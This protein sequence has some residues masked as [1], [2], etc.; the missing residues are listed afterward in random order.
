MPQILLSTALVDV[1]DRTGSWIT[2]R[3]LLDSASQGHFVTE[4]L[5]QR[6][7]LKKQRLQTPIRGINNS[8]TEA[9]HSIEIQ[10]KSRTGAFETNIK[11]SVLTSI[12]GYMPAE[13]VET[14]SW[15][16]PSDIKLADPTFHT[17]GRIDMLLGTEVFFA[18]LRSEKKPRTA[19]RPFLQNTELGWILA[20]EVPSTVTSPAPSN[21]FFIRSEGDLGQQLQRF[22]EIEEIHMKPHSPEETACENHFV[23]NTTRDLSGRFIVKLPLKED[24][25]VLGDSLNSSVIRYQQLERRLKTSCIK[26]TIR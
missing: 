15:N 17:S 24:R 12:T 19:S 8:A 2:C 10:I 7:R 14:T 25:S 13:R 23:Q 11:C 3:A 20:G 5:S 21:S 9:N 26:G 6:L 18:A 16:I 22:W 4:D 1:R